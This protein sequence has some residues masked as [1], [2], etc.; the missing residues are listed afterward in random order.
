MRLEVRLGDW[1]SPQFAFM[2]FRHLLG[3]IPALFDYPDRES[4]A[5]ADKLFRRVR[6]YE[7]PKP[8]ERP[9][10]NDH[11]VASP[12]PRQCQDFLGRACSVHQIAKVRLECSTSYSTLT[13]NY[14]GAVQDTLFGDL[15]CRNPSGLVCS[16]ASFFCTPQLN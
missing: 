5:L 7:F 10:S 12:R 6:V 13:Q 4:F 11:G 9:S 16:K 1:R 3:G 14:I 15:A 8:R 2:A